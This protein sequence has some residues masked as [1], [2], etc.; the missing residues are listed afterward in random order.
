[1]Y[2][3]NC[4]YNLINMCEG[5]GE[6]GEVGILIFVKVIEVIFFFIFG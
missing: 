5:G 6:V 2:I 1:M 3:Y 4:Y